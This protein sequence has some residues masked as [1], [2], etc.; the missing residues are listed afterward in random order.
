LGA[1]PAGEKEGN[2]GGRLFWKEEVFWIVGCLGRTRKRERAKDINAVLL[3][4]LG[5]R[6]PI[7]EPPVHN[8]PLHHPLAHRLD[9]LLHQ[10][11]KQR[12]FMIIAR[13]YLHSHKK[14]EIQPGGRVKQRHHLITPP[15]L[16]AALL[17]VAHLAVLRLRN[18]MVVLVKEKFDRP[19]I[20][21]IVRNKKVG[22][23]SD[24]NPFSI[25]GTVTAKS[26]DP[27]PSKPSHQ[28]FGILILGHLA[29][30]IRITRALP[31]IV[32]LAVKPL[33]ADRR[34]PCLRMNHLAPRLRSKS[35]KHPSRTHHHG[36]RIKGMHP[37]Q[38]HGKI[39]GHIKP[40]RHLLF[41]PGRGIAL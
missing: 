30:K 28:R 20:A 11:I 13:D 19:L 6:L 31:I 33:T 24:E 27:I 4:A 8:E 32:I 41:L 34:I 25:K 21:G 16:T 7:Q 12:T 1:G 5:D 39:A 3:L 2:R 40:E 9:K 35:L 23:I 36:K 17:I 18:G 14:E 29:E 37:V 26:P 22:G 15:P 38:S 10:G